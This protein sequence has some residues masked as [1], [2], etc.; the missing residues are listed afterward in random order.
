MK[1]KINR[2][3]TVGNHALSDE[4]VIVIIGKRINVTCYA[5]SDSKIIEN[6]IEDSEES[7]KNINLL[8]QSIEGST[9][10]TVKYLW[11]E[12]RGEHNQK[13]FVFSVVD[14]FS[15][16]A[17]AANSKAQDYPT[18]D[19]SAHS[20]I[21]ASSGE[22]KQSVFVPT[23]LEADYRVFHRGVTLMLKPC[24]DIS[25]YELWNINKWIKFCE[26][27]HHASVDQIMDKAVEAGIMRH[28]KEEG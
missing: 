15:G 28:F 25:A 21:D 20:S 11:T 18:F 23:T 24:E 16:S 9:G 17:K 2:V 1:L 8:I 26:I 22:I 12:G 7:L 3:V 14:V 19:D 27:N 6:Y 10:Y 5:E 4:A 13:L